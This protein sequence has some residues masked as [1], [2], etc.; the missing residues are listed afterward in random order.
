[1]IK[2]R[3]P[4]VRVEL[5]PGRF[6]KMY[7]KDAGALG[8]LKPSPQ[9]KVRRPG[10]DKMRRPEGDKGQ[11]PPQPSP[12][13]GEEAEVST[14][15]ITDDFTV[16][17]GIGEATAAMLRE[18]GILTLEVLREMETGDLPARVARA[19]ERWRDGE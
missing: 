12:K 19:I 3:G 18:R 11:P 16:I 9:G 1:M 6:V 7:K 15:V 8:L 13:E 17:P 14:R 5:E 10:G 4:L 2:S